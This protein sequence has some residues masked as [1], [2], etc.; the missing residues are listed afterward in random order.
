MNSYVQCCTAL[1][2]IVHHILLALAVVKSCMVL[3]F[4]IERQGKC[5]LHFKESQNFA[6]KQSEIFSQN[7]QSS[8]F[9]HFT[10]PTT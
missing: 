4:N 2:I 10:T 5:R 7:L 3:T 6:W 8:H 1:I 9:S